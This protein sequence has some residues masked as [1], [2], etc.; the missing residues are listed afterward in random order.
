M[1]ILIS[2]QQIN[3]G[4]NFRVYAEGALDA[5]V[6]KYFDEAVSADVKVTKEGSDIKTEVTVHP[7]TGAIVRASAVSADA[8]A[9]LDGAVSRLSRQLRKY[10]NR[11]VEH[12]N[13]VV[14]MVD[15][16]VIETSTDVEEVADAPVI[17][18]E[19]QTQLPVCTVSEAV[20]R[21]DLEGLPA[22]MFKNTAHGG[23]NLVYR[24]ADGNIGWVDPKSK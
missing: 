13:Q 11:L 4:D 19:M 3:L 9:S 14:E 17:I 12:K 20:M 15:F 18:A 8:Y 5:S 21:M 22:L 23:L 6:S 1:Q 24:R 7:K 10:K 16:S 2:G